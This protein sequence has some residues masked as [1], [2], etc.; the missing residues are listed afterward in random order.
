MGERFAERDTTGH[1]KP[2]AGRRANAAWRQII[3][4]IK[5]GVNVADLIRRRG[6]ELKFHGKDLIGLCPF[7]N[8]KK[9]SLVVTPSK[10]L[11]H[12]LG[13]CQEGGDVIACPVL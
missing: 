1:L 3:D 9:P 7:H 13:A 12:C 4:E 11:W 6:I 10:N 8:D 5:S 2:L